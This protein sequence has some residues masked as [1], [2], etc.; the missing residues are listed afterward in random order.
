MK[1]YTRTYKYEAGQ[2]CSVDN[3]NNLVDVED[4]LY[5]NC[6]YLLNRC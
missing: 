3:C 5:D 6:L 4:V 2:K 1:I